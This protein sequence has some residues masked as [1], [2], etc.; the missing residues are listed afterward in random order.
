MNVDL[1]RKIDHHLG[2]PLTFVSTYVLKTLY[3]LKGKKPATPKNILFVELSEMGST[4]IADPAMKRAQKVFDANLFFVIFSKNKP[5]LDLLKTIP[6]ENIFTLCEDNLFTLMRDAVRYLFWCRKNRIDTAIDLELFSRVS[7]LLTGFSGANNRI[8]YHNFHGEGLYRGE[9]L[10]HKVS[11]NPHI[12]IAKNF[13]ALI[14]ALEA[15]KPEVPYAKVLISDDHIRLDQV[16]FSDDE[17]EFVHQKVADCYADYDRDAHEL[18]LINPNASDLL[19][20]RRWPKANFI[21]LM[22]QVLTQYPN[23]LVLITGAPNEREE[24][25]QLL[26]QVDHERCINFAGQ[27]KLLQMPILYSIARLMVT[28]DSGPGHFSAITPLKTF[29]LFGPETPKLYGSLGNSTP[30]F[31]GLACSPCVSAA[32]HRKTPCTEPVCMDAITVDT[33]F[34][35]V[36]IELNY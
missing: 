6:Q 34:K 33:V 25:Q 30:I 29:V 24:A 27:L 2:V 9:M 18:V 31:A 32:N 16:T 11:Y 36:Q 21:A 22:Q 28:N 1:M 26:E 15:P 13:M 19:P 8:G 17:K 35:Q 23:A 3:W 7:A 14:H 5:S 4:I 20:Q 10:T 12:H